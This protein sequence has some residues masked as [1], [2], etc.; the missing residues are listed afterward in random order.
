M[1]K[2]IYNC[3]VQID[4]KIREII[5]IYL[6]NATR[7]LFLSK[8]D[9]SRGAFDGFTHALWQSEIISQEEYFRLVRV[10]AAIMSLAKKRGHAL[11][12][13]TVRKFLEEIQ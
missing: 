13:K 8:C 4:A 9:Y 2:E 11:S 12:Y 1:A 3:S 5:E 6:V 7:N 10:F